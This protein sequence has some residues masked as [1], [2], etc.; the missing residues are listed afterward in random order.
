MT[1]ARPF[2]AVLFDFG[3]V[4]TSSPFVA[5]EAMAES[6][7][8]TGDVVL[9]LIFGPYD[10]D[11]DHAWH[12]AERGEIPL[13]D[14]RVAILAAAA[15]Q[16]LTLDL[17]QLLAFMSDGSGVRDE[18]VTRT[19]AIRAAGMRTALVTNNVV[20]FADFWRPMLPLD[21]LFDAVVDSSEVRMRKPDPAIYMHTLQLI[22][23][24][25]AERAVF[26]DDYHGNVAAAERLGMQGILV[27]A[28]PQ[29]AYDALDALL[30]A[31]RP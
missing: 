14:A 5:A 19:R 4:Y 1:D 30:D 29:S 17:Y 23:E 27:G 21:E 10:T 12:R 25:P 24:V 15:E 8:A 22:G 9:P 7:G 18:M 13:E 11:S 2:E 16:G 20:E 31:R 3:G 28:D 6:I 26:V